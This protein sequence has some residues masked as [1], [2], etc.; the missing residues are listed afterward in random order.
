MMIEQ[1]SDSYVLLTNIDALQLSVTM[2]HTQYSVFVVEL[3][4]RSPKVFEK[5]SLK[6]ILWVRNLYVSIIHDTKPGT[7]IDHPLH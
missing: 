2:D 7:C 5:R 3:Q 4:Q 1:Y 6:S